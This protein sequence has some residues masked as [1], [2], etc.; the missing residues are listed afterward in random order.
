[1][2]TINLSHEEQALLEKLGLDINKLAAKEKR[3][4][5]PRDTSRAPITHDLS[6]QSGQIEKHCKGC[7]AITTSYFDLVKRLDM[8]GYA[9]KTVD[10]PSNPIKF[11]Q[12]HQVLGCPECSDELLPLLPD[13]ELIRII[14]NLRRG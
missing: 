1:M 7:G 5:T 6:K 8:E 9:T 12:K 4:N 2:P 10:V 3:A 14:K 13:A 11:K